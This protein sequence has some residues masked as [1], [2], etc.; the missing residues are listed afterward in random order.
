LQFELGHPCLEPGHLGCLPLNRLCR[1]GERDPLLALEIDGFADPLGQVEHAVIVAQS[2]ADPGD[3]HAESL[4]RP[5]RHAVCSVKAYQFWYAHNLSLF[6]S[7]CAAPLG[8]KTRQV[9]NLVPLGTVDSLRC[10]E[11]ARH[12]SL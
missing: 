7:F 3:V 11:F 6:A 5:S 1:L 2:S 4:A 10:I 9:V 12:D 8:M